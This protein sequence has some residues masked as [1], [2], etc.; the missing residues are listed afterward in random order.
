[1]FIII[2]KDNGLMV[3][4][5]GSYYTYTKDIFNAR[6]FSNKEQA[7]REICPGNEYVKDIGYNSLLD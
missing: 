6:I 7:Q 2:N 4:K 5:S 1:M 3:A